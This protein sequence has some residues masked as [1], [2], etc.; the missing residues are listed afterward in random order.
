VGLLLLA[1]L[2]V[3]ATPASA[4]RTPLPL[5]SAPAVSPTEQLLDELRADELAGD[6]VARG[7]R[8]K[9]P[10]SAAA[11][12]IA[13]PRASAER[14]FTLFEAPPRASETRLWGLELGLERQ[15]LPAHAFEPE[16]AVGAS[17]YLFDALGSP[18]TLMAADG[19]VRER[20]KLDAWGVVRE[21]TGA[22]ENPFAFTGHELDDETGLYYARA[23][24]YDPE[25]GRF[26]SEDPFGGE[27]ETPPSLH[28]YLYAFDAPTVYVDLSGRATVVLPSGAQMWVPDA[29]YRAGKRAVGF[30]V[31]LGSEGY[32]V[33]RGMVRAIRDNAVAP[34]AVRDAYEGVVRLNRVVQAYRQ[35]GPE[36]ARVEQR[37]IANEV[38]SQQQA[39]LQ[40]LPVAQT[41]IAGLEVP[42]AYDEGG[43]F[44]ASS[45]VGRATAR[46]MLDATLVFGLFRGLSP[47]RAAK[48]EVPAPGEAVVPPGEVPS[49]VAPPALGD[50]GVARIE[51]PEGSTP[52]PQA[53]TTMESSGPG[54]VDTATP[55]TMPNPTR[56]G[57]DPVRVGQHGEA[58]STELHGMSKNTRRIPS[59]S[60]KREYRVPDQMDPAGRYIGEVKAVQ[61]QHLSSQILDDKAYV[62][63]GGSPGRVDVT[64]DNST[65]VTPQLLREHLDPGSPIK[66]REAALKKK[67]PGDV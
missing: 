63:R 46:A 30:T 2:A 43:E 19:S 42:E 60:G 16:I 55:P 67:Q 66:L 33:A 38:L 36:A 44:A 22:S 54:V 34:P 17:L 61:K 48:P 32:Q 31:G 41:V 1:S 27:A 11:L 14:R 25:L 20:V 6:F 51:A 15:R 50:A 9:A 26:L 56:G 21:R 28:R 64:I 35:G 53:V 45:Q 37:N 47:A 52:P 57:V 24:F 59:A 39:Q 58:V 12:A 18:V 4:S 13:S 3:L 49:A 62:L 40:S 65:A 7:E 5:R 10:K 8:T 23:R 29:V